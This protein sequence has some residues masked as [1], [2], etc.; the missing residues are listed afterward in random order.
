GRKLGSAVSRAA[1]AAGQH[2]T[3]HVASSA[4]AATFT[5]ADLPAP[6]EVDALTE[7]LPEGMKR[8]IQEDFANAQKQMAK[9]GSLPDVTSEI[10][11]MAIGPIILAA[12]PGEVVQEIGF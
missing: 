4:V 3:R 5:F 9:R 7:S 10:Q 1:R 12:M 11:A 2:S 6:Q 8:L